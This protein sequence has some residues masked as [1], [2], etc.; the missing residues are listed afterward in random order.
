MS[1]IQFVLLLTL[2]SKVV[3]Y[4][5]FISVFLEKVEKWAGLILI[6]LGNIR[7]MLSRLGKW[8]LWFGFGRVRVC[9][10]FGELRLCIALGWFRYGGGQLFASG[11]QDSNGL[12]N[13]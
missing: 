9:F 13:L 1:L 12:D 6:S 7:R 10:D 4:G 8:L 2:G 11:F 5:S 3:L